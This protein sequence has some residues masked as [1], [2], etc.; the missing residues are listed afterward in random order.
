MRF[1]NVIL[2][3]TALASMAYGFPTASVQMVSRDPAPSADK[4]RS[5]RCKYHLQS[6]FPK[7]VHRHLFRDLTTLL[8]PHRPSR[9]HER[10][11]DLLLPRARRLRPNLFS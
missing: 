5:K 8:A 4:V 7:R 1:T 11:N 3:I 6:C 10:Q 2:S 9:Q